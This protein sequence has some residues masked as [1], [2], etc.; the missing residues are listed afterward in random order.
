MPADRGLSNP[1]A[2]GGGQGGLVERIWSGQGFGARLARA[3]LAPASALYAAAVG[4]RGALYDRGVLKVGQPV[5]PAVSVGNLTVGGCVSAAAF[6][7]FCSVTMAKATRLQ[8]TGFS[9]RRRRSLRK[10]IGWPASRGWPMRAAMSRC[11][12][13]AFNTGAWRAQWTWCWSVPM[14]GLRRAGIYRPVRGENRS[15]QFGE[16]RRSSLLAR[17]R[18]AVRSPQ[19]KPPLRGSRLQSRWPSHRWCPASCGRWRASRVRCTQC[20]IFACGPSREW[21]GRR[22][23]WRS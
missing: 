18:R 5:I 17:W 11:W 14:R 13:T 21:V 16:R 19:S 7:A 8:F 20:G 4:V 15:K 1:E 12:T 6:P 9:T 23:F 10:P 3:S 2:E 22:R